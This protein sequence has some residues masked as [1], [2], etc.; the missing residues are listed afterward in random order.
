MKK[1][2]AGELEEADHYLKRCEVEGGDP[3][4]HT[5]DVHIP[6]IVQRCCVRA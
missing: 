4:S 2:V 3:R 5:V 6:S 1:G